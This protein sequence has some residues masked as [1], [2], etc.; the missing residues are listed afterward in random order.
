MSPLR[1][2]PPP[3][4]GVFWRFRWVRQ[5]DEFAHSPFRV[6]WKFLAWTLRESL[7]RDMA[8]S[9][10]DGK[11]F[12]SMPNNFSSLALHIAGN[13]DPEIHKFIRRHL[14][15][16]AVMCDIGA[17]IGAYAVLLGPAVGPTGRVIAFEAH[18]VCYGYLQQNVRLNQLTN[19]T[20]ENKG[21][22]DQVGEL[23]IEYDQKNPGQTHIDLQ[24]ARDSVRIPVSTLDAE[25][26]RLNVATVDYIKIDVEGFE[27]F[28]LK[29]ASKTISASPDLVV[30]TEL[31]D[32]YCKRYGYKTVD[33]L[34][35]MTGLGFVAHGVTPDGSLQKLPRDAVL[36]GDILWRRAAD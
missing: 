15:P 10:P 11:R 34:D 12:T 5:T 27:L 24:G 7:G 18:P 9:T 22:G 36:S 29:G 6:T 25:L 8:F 4:R 32:K 3:I 17:N 1:L 30:Q 31:F 14:K 21:L 23:R 13:R 26:A 33:V 35:F 20:I 2:L 28:V 19:V 16:G